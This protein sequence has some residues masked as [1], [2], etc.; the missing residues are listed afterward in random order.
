MSHKEFN[1]TGLCIPELHYMADMSSKIQE[2]ITRFISR[3][4]YFTINRARQYGKTT[5][6]RLLEHTLKDSY[7]VIRI[8]F[9]GKEEYFSSLQ[10]LAGGL[11]LSFSQSLAFSYPKLARIFKPLPDTVYPM[12]D[13][14]N[15]I[16]KLCEKSQKPV[17]L[18]IDEVDKA[19][20]NETFLSF[21]G[22][23]RQMYLARQDYGAPAF[24]NVILAGVHDIKNLKMKI[25]PEERH[26]YN[27][28]WNIAA[29]FNVDMSLS[30]SDITGMLASYEQ[31]YP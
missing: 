24:S 21:L 10:S 31:D 16:I 27:S 15:R 30:L 11:S 12:Q 28:P 1:I 23:L 18:M 26:T 19:S 7:V 13:L 3:G 22:M 17:I 6:L 4:A 2:I 25:R 9:E 8:S 20:N 29:D 14:N 5:T